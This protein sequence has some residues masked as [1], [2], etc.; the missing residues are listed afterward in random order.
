LVQSN[1][2]LFT[3]TVSEVAPLQASALVVVQAQLFWSAEHVPVP[4]AQL[5]PLSPQLTV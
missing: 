3:V 1:V 5:P 2:Q 4:A